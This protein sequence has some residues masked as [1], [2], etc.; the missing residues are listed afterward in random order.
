MRSTQSKT[1]KL[2]L[3]TTISTRCAL[4]GGWVHV[5][6]ASV[7]CA[8]GDD[9]KAVGDRVEVRVCVDAG[10]REDGFLTGCRGRDLD[11]CGRNGG[12]GPHTLGQVILRGTKE[13]AHGRTEVGE[14][15][16]LQRR[17]QL[18]RNEGRRGLFRRPVELGSLVAGGQVVHQG[19]DRSGVLERALCGSVRDGTRGARVSFTLQRKLLQHILEERA[20]LILD[21]EGV[22]V[23]ERDAHSLEE[24]T[25]IGVLFNGRVLDFHGDRGGWRDFL[26]PV[27]LAGTRE[28]HALVAALEELVHHVERR[29][30]ME[31]ATG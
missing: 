4:L 21:G 20:D 16:V 10:I 12:Q 31:I 25:E 5:S 17:E 27:A 24:D 6:D 26:G 2:V 9:G 22:K 23:F 14:H 8:S 1:A 30:A 7:V 11:L 29:A 3:R 28:G 18:T 13:F 15:P 19:V